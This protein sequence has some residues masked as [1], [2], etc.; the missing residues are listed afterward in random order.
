MRL[1]SK[2]PDE[3]RISDVFEALEGP[4]AIVDCLGGHDVCERIEG[5][6]ARGMWSELNDVMA[7][8]LETTTLA[9]LAAKNTETK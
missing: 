5:C 4:L 7:G 9:D 2:S 6:R 3:I 1:A 8:Y